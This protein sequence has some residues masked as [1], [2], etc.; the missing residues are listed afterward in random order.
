MAS[1]GLERQFIGQGRTVV[2]GKRLARSEKTEDVEALK[3]SLALL[4]EDQLVPQRAVDLGLKLE[5]PD[6][7]YKTNWTYLKQISKYGS[8]ARKIIDD[9]PSK[10]TYS[11]VIETEEK[12]VT[13]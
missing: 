9:Y 1:L 2:L 11:V 8:K 3:K 4:V 6:P 10:T 12:N 5:T 13:E 7:Y